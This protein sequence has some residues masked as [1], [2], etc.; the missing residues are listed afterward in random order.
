MFCCRQKKIQFKIFILRARETFEVKWLYFY[1]IYMCT[2]MMIY[3]CEA[4]ALFCCKKK[5]MFEGKLQGKCTILWNSHSF[6]YFLKNHI[7]SSLAPKRN[8]TS[9]TCMQK[10]RHF[11]KLIHLNFFLCVCRFY[12]H[13][14]SCV[15][16]LCAATNDGWTTTTMACGVRKKEKNNS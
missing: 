8:C 4:S 1:G 2:F 11:K 14:H 10:E 6:Y 16:A 12:R 15:V 13:S 7:S 9:K 5:F 3:W